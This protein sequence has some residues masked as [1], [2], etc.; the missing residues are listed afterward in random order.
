MPDRRAEEGHDP[1]AH[2][3]VH[4][5]LVVVDGLHHAFKDRVEE[6]PGLLGVAVGEQF[7]G[8]LQVAEEHRDLL[9]FAFEG[10]TGGE[11]FLGEVLRGVGLRG[12]EARS[13]RFREQ[14]RAL[15]TEFIAGR[16]GRT[17]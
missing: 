7:H 5:A 8:P 12:V 10:T 13:G 3:L 1:V 16:I 4:G 2:H 11:D 17:A 6:L 9:A 14:C 15:A